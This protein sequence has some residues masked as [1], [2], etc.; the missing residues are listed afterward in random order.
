MLR[1]C[2]DGSFALRTRPCL[3]YHIKRCTAPC[4]GKVAA[5]DYARQVAEALDFLRGKTHDIQQA[6]AL[7]M[8]A[9]SD[10]LDFELAASLRDRIKVLSSIQS[11]Q[12]INSAGLG[13]A[14]IFAL[15][16]E[17]GHTAI[18]VFFFRADRNYGTRTYYPAHDRSMAVGEILASFI[19]QFYADK[20]VPPLLLLSH[21]AD[22][23]ALLAE[24]LG[25]KAGGKVSILV[26]KHGEKK[27]VMDHALQNAQAALGRKLS[28]SS[29]Q[30]RLLQR[31]GELFG[32]AE[33]PKRIEVYDNSHIA[34][35]HAVGAMIAA[36]AEGFL[37]KT[38]RKFNIK[39]ARTNNDFAM[40]T[41]VLTRRF[42]RLLD[43]DPERS[44]G[45]WPDLLLIDGGQG[46]LGK[47][48]AV[49]TALGVGDITVVGI[50]KGPD[51]NAGR[52]RFLSA[53][54]NSACRRT[55]RR[56]ITCRGCAT[57]RIGSPSG[58]IAPNAPR[59][60]A[61]PDWRR[62]QASARCGRRRFCTI[63]VRPKPWRGPESRI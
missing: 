43:E 36:G 5:E 26:P 57:R 4:V 61:F 32:M 23:A 44:S 60:S 20:P 49:M 15:H 7:E 12:G 38:Y 63:S 2:T 55:I 50:A 1:N 21:E 62:C 24:A 16:Q 8:Q 59:P 13:D 45:L 51:R 14:D 48:L 9:A 56:F 30:A 3:Q 40:M 29:E 47:V 37:K 58:R 17:A 34:G 10:R 42:Q 6:M 25:E 19:A 11:K 41:E 54:R 35:A 18:Q 52:E 31:V 22:E 46:Q 53:T 28:E 39:S 33:A 27:R